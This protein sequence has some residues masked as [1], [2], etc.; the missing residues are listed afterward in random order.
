MFSTLAIEKIG[1]HVGTNLL[2]LFHIQNG[3][4]GN[5]VGFLL[6]LEL[7]FSGLYRFDSTVSME[8]CNCM[9]NVSVAE[10]IGKLPIL[11]FSV[12]FFLWVFGSSFDVNTKKSFLDYDVEI[13][14]FRNRTAKRIAGAI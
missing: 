2:A 5:F 7:H 12:F 8:H 4:N 10:K 6:S 13:S 3:T 1:S 11:F 9:W 14:I